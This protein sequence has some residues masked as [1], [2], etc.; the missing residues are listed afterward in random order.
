MLKSQAQ[1]QHGNPQSKVQANSLPRCLR[2]SGTW[3]ALEDA[4][5]IVSLLSE[6]AFLNLLATE[7]KDGGLFRDEL[8][9]GGFDL[10]VELLQDK[11]DIAAEHYSFPFVGHHDSPILAKRDEEK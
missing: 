11:L 7:H 4:R 10:L 9:A 3:E 2:H 8:T 1:S 6:I 5:K